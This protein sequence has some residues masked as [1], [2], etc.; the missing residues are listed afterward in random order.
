ME[1]K[2]TVSEYF[3]NENGLRVH[4]SVKYLNSRA[5]TNGLLKLRSKNLSP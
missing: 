1:E 3:L 4:R 2:K 5:N